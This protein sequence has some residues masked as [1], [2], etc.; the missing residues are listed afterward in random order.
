[1]IT[2]TKTTNQMHQMQIYKLR[3][4]LCDAVR[5]I[6]ATKNIQRNICI[7]RIFIFTGNLCHRL[8]K[9]KQENKRTIWKMIFMWMQ[10]REVDIVVANGMVG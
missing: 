1:M 2:M 8:K 5:H 3:C 6:N 4:H 9:K 10:N 7:R